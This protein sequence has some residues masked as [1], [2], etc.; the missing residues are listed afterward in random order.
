MALFPGHS[1]YPLLESLSSENSVQDEPLGL[2]RLPGQPSSGV[3][4]GNSAA[5]LAIICSLYRALY[6]DAAAGN[7]HPVPGAECARAVTPRLCEKRA[8]GERCAEAIPA[9]AGDV[10]AAIAAW[11]PVGAPAWNVRIGV[12]PRRRCE[13]DGGCCCDRR[14]DYYSGSC[15]CYGLLVNGRAKAFSKCPLVGKASSCAA[16]PR[17]DYVRFRWRLPLYR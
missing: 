2:L 15:H 9:A 12:G 10:L 16:A 7:T 17:G 1:K 6:P 11:A 14:R 8:I 3:D 5:S 13:R 4:A